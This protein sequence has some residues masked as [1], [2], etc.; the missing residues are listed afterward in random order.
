MKALK[1][2][3][4]EELIRYVTEGSLAMD[5]KYVICALFDE[6]GLPKAVVFEKDDLRDCWLDLHMYASFDWEQIKSQV[7][8]FPVSL[9]FSSLTAVDILTANVI[10]HPQLSLGVVKH[11]IKDALRYTISIEDKTQLNSCKL[12]DLDPG[13][14]PFDQMNFLDRLGI[15]FKKSNRE[16]LEDSYW[17]HIWNRR[18]NIAK[19]VLDQYAGPNFA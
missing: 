9:G 1:L 16:C 2:F 4:P 11:L 12:L 10:V 3:S 18:K 19:V 6:R 7:F 5:S 8:K 15:S 13:F 17:T 14:V